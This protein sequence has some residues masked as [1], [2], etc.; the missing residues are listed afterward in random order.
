MSWA[1][2]DED[3][4]TS[5]AAAPPAASAAPP[6]AS[7]ALTQSRLQS[8]A[9]SAALTQSHLRSPAASTAGPSRAGKHVRWAEGEAFKAVR[10][11]ERYIKDL[12][13]DAEGAG[14]AGGAGAGAAGGAGAGAAYTA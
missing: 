4:M 11:V 2:L 8:P 10:I 7:A 5:A 6:A 14:A 12:P 1:D 3:Y 9:A 13:E